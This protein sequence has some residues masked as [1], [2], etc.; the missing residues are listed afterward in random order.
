MWCGLVSQLYSTLCGLM[1]YSLLGSAYVKYSFCNEI[2]PNPIEDASRQQKPGLFWEN[3]KGRKKG[4]ELKQTCWNGA[5]QNVGWTKDK[6]KT[7]LVRNWVGVGQDEAF[8]SVAGSSQ[9]PGWPRMYNS[10]SQ[11][12]AKVVWLLPTWPVIWKGP[13]LHEASD[14]LKLFQGLKHDF[15]RQCRKVLSEIKNRPCP[16]SSQFLLH[17]FI[18]VWCIR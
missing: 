17:I 16:F 10:F 13:P 4:T 14:M 3:G 18:S 9:Q 2:N 12:S 1:D 15:C 7:E 5:R 8:A 11:G 6:K